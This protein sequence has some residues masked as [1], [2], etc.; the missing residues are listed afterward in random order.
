LARRILALW[1]CLGC[2]HFHLLRSEVW[3]FPL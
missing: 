2:L 3:K 1:G